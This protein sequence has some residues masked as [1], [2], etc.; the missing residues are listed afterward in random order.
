VSTDVAGDVIVLLL[1]LVGV[2]AS[3]GED[4]ADGGL[5]ALEAVLQGEGLF[6][7]ACQSRYHC[8]WRRFSKG[9]IPSRQWKQNSE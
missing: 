7:N 9:M 8:V 6:V 3:E 1:L 4:G 2:G 5:V